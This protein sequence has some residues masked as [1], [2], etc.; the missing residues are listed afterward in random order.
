[1]TR[2]RLFAL[3]TA[4][5]TI[6]AAIG[7]GVYFYSNSVQARVS[8]ARSAFR[9]GDREDA[10]QLIEA[11][12]ADHPESRDAR[13]LATKI[14][15]DQADMSVAGQHI[16][17]LAENAPDAAT[18]F[19]AQIAEA[20]INAEQFD[21]AEKWFQ[22]VL[23]IDPDNTAALKEL[24]QLYSNAGRR[25]ESYSLVLKLID[26]EEF[27]F[28][29]LLF[30]AR[31]EDMLALPREYIADRLADR[32]QVLPLLG[33]AR[34]AFVTSDP[35]RAEA[36]VREVIAKRPEILEA[37]LRLCEILLE[38]RPAEFPAEVLKLPVEAQ[39]HPLYWTMLGK[40][41]RR[42]GQAKLAAASFRESLL[43]DPNRNIATFQLSQLLP[44]L[45]YP[46][47]AEAFRTRADE[48]GTMA[49]EMTGFF[50]GSAN[51]VTVR[52]V[53]EKLENLGRYREAIAW[54][55]HASRDI[56]DTWPQEVLAKLEPL[57]TDSIVAAEKDPVRLMEAGNFPTPTLEDIARVA[58]GNKGTS[59]DSSESFSPIQLANVAE[60][61]GAKFQY[62][63]GAV[64]NS[65]E[66][67][68]Y[69]FTGGGVGVIDFDLDGWPEFYLPNGTR[70]PPSPEQTEFHD[71][72]FRNGVTAFENVTELAGIKEWGFGQGVTVGDFNCDGFP[73]LYVANT[74]R[75]QLW[76]NNGDGTFSD[77]TDSAGLTA[78]VWTTSCVVVD[79]NGDSLP[80]IYD[81][82]FLTGEDVFTR[83]CDEEGRPRS[84]PPAEFPGEQDLVFLNNGDGSF[85]NVTNDSGI[86]RPRGNGLGIIAA[87][88]DGSRRLNLFLAND[89]VANF[90]YTNESSGDT[91]AFTESAVL[92]GLDVNNS[93]KSQACMG[94]GLA[95]IDA[96]GL[97]DLFITNFHNES[98]ALYMQ[99]SEN[100][101]SDEA[102]PTNIRA[103]SLDMLGFGTQFI[104][105]DLNARPDLVITNGHVDDY[106]HEGAEYQMRP[107]V[108]RLAATGTRFFEQYPEQPDPYFSSKHLGRGLARLDFNRDGLDDYGVQHLDSP[109][110]LVRNDTKE[111]GN[112]L[113]LKLIGTSG[114]RDAIGAQVRVQAGEKQM[115]HQ[116][117]GGDGYMACNER[118]LT[119]GLGDF[120][121]PCAISVDWMSGQT[122]DF[123]S[124]L[125]N[126]AVILVEGSTQA[127]SEPK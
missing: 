98:N 99:Q 51:L 54:A 18:D 87:D 1:M 71:A 73:D 55:K 96:N 105:L 37:K 43:L 78:S 31:V 89:S 36:L 46:K 21:D 2:S 110:A 107:Q 90:Y 113:S 25:W 22:R 101:F 33:I 17:W 41:F 9:N 93:G 106:T 42:E 62:F 4:L 49:N 118:R 81:V 11:V 60:T 30:A 63:N 15:I 24:T 20:Q 124:V 35:E 115:V 80:D 28:N 100:L 40:W 65:E 86:V 123:G 69:E 103:L 32:T 126:A 57:M 108:L 58:R 117:A 8:E 34:M 70:W 125:P 122:E 82:N 64:P 26:S 59:S 16:D 6:A 112:F 119:I 14:A 45:G 102:K 66:H 23:E 95:D 68:M 38:V 75:N 47:Q 3:L 12:I 72:L 67:R 84:C 88:F 53:I 94:V 127:F 104:D 109:F 48:L 13:E 56:T 74:Q 61:L 50:R 116:L 120:A 79:L 83:V 97:P 91:I 29:H 76:Q 27:D 77:A 111:H 7:A 39:S 92:A 52:K 85:S 19:A 10:S 121:N 114:A 5:A 44:Q